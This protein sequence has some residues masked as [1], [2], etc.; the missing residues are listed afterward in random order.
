MV[1]FPLDEIIANTHWLKW[2]PPFVEKIFWNKHKTDPNCIMFPWMLILNSKVETNDS[3]KILLLKTMTYHMKQNIGLN[4]NDFYTFTFH[5]DYK[6][7]IPILKELNIHT[8]YI[9]NKNIT[10]TEIDGIKIKYEHPM[11]NNP[12]INANIKDKLLQ[13]IP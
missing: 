1:S 4:A 11:E 2:S 3:L 9:N 13:V 5:K 6:R 12:N 10:E 7:L 8:L